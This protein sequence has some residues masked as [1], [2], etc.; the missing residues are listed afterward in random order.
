MDS[1]GVRLVETRSLDHCW[2]L[3]ARWPGSFVVAEWS[4]QTADGLLVRL[5]RRER[6]FPLARVA[7]V[8]DRASAG[9]ESLVREAG[10]VWFVTS[11]RGLAPLV[12]IA[13]RHLATVSRPRT[14]L[15]QRLW[16]TLPW[17]PAGE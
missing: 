5:A 11:P 14:T 17:R 4:P 1:E 3:L 9:D 15:A 7:V 13:R 16:A 12:A 8:A 6:K 2:E 10:A